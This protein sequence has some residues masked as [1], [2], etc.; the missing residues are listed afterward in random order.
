MAAEISQ[1]CYRS[2]EGEPLVLVHG[3]TATWRCWLP[4]LDGLS[5]HFEVIAPTLHGHHGGPAVPGEHAQ[6]MAAAADHLE[7]LLDTLGVGT[8]HVAGNSMGGA[9]ALELAKR[10]RAR[11]VVAISPGG[12]WQPGDRREA[13]R[14]ARLFARTQRLAKALDS[15][16]ATIVAPPRSRRAA[17]RDV[18][19]HGELVPPAEALQLIQSSIRCD[20]VPNVLAALRDGR[21]HLT[22]LEQIDCPV[23]VAWGDR[24]RILPLS[25][26]APRFR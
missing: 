26:H 18:M 19:A 9:L 22:G 17:L 14:I 3:F 13:V 12:G 11:S 20:T 1:A 2:G 10:G 23:L 15:R 16:T 8:A 7:Q 24:D 5:E 25:R 4:V 21:A 6:T